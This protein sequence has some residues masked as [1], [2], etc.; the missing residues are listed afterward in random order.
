MAAS[1]AR[2][3][4]APATLV[5]G[6]EA[7][8]IHSA[9]IRK[10]AWTQ[11]PVRRL[12]A[13]AELYLKEGPWSVT[14]DR[15]KGIDLDPHEYYSEAPY[16]WPDPA[17][18]GGPLL[19]RTGQVNPSR[20]TA[21]RTALDAACD[22]VF[23]LGTAAYL[24][25]DARYAR[26][27]ARIVQAW[28]ISPR[29]R[30]EPSMEHAGVIPGTKSG[31]VSGLGGGISEGRPLIRA[32]QGMEFLSESGEWDARDAAAARK[33]FE[34]YLRWLT[35]KGPAAGSRRRPDNSTWRAALT[36]AAASFAEDAAA[37]QTAFD[38]YRARILPRP[39][40][41]GGPTPPVQ[42]PALAAGLEA[43]ATLCRIAQVHGVD[44][45]SLRTRSGVTIATPIDNLE[46]S[47]ADPKQWSKEQTAAFQGHGV[48]LLAFAGMGLNK[49]EYVALYRK[50]EHPESSWL[51]LVDLL[52]GRWEAAGHQT[53]H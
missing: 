10:E 1:L 47:L 7:G 52:V 22:A 27:A 21:N 12:R 18:P 23:T 29:T 49:P 5:S 38:A 36:A 32:I 25:D 43:R 6:D 51:A 14:S 45:W 53:R 24:L 40:R 44:L 3:A 39:P 48:Y 46:A 33:W 26:R 15:P 19:R 35:P 2:A 30:M 42:E 13:E 9:V 34:E 20:F 16:Y 37:R 11:D 28:F 4:D 50:W 31:E 8:P 41:A 17:N